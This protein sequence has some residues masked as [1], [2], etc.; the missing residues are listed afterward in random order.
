MNPKKPQALVETNIPRITGLLVIEVRDSN[1][2][3][4]PE[5]AGFPRQRPDSRGEIS[6]V[7]I[8][9]KLRDLVAEKNGLVWLKLKQ[10]LS[11]S[12]DA[13]S[14]FEIL[15]SRSR[16]RSTI[17]AE[18]LKGQFDGKYWDARLFGSTFLEGRE[19]VEKDMGRKLNDGE[20][21]SLQKT[22]RTGV[23]HF[24]VGISIAPV[25]IRYETWTN[26]SGVE[27]GKDRGLAP[28]AL[29]YVQHGIYAV[30]FFVNPT[31]AQ[32][33]GCTLDDVQVMLQLLQHTY[34]DNASTGRNQV[35]IIH[36]HTVQHTDPLGS[37]SDFALL[38]YLAPKRIPETDKNTPSES[39]ADYRIPMWEDIQDKTIRQ[40]KKTQWSNVGT[41]KDY[42]FN[43][44]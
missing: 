35:E 2:N 31:Q 12:E 33:T 10:R 8:K 13:N 11:L 5:N 30:P 25:R 42:A 36:A 43:S 27:V 40:G 16:V 6:P 18:M 28:Q 26:N 29:K 23:A 9:R 22:I 24:G 1:P 20:W 44:E 37:F 7:S 14:R 15:E 4:D 3:G 21:Q 38:D 41:Y 32:K 19:A 17:I 39:R 34:R